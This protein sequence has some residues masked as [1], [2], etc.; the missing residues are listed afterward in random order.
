MDSK[1]I[2]KSTPP[3]H[4]QPDQ[5]VPKRLPLPG[6]QESL[7][8]LQGMIGNQAL[9]RLMIQ[10][11]I[12][13]EE[14]EV[15][16]EGESSGPV[17]LDE[18]EVPVE[19]S[20]D[21]SGAKVGPDGVWSFPPDHGPDW[22]GKESTPEAPQAP[23]DSTDESGAKVGPD[24]VWQFPPDHVPHPEG[25]EYGPATPQAPKDSTDDSGAKTGPDGV[26]EFPPDHVPSSDEGGSWMENLPFF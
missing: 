11:Q 14:M 10:R 24:G 13:M 7:M 20:A 25:K 17:V 12:E 6:N 21:E 16:V 2:P 23:K 4:R 8:R 3:T 18:M 15:P 5:P 22:D 1:R 9:Q 19:G 26:V